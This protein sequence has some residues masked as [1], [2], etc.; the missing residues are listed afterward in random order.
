MELGSNV[1]MFDDKY[2]EL[3]KILN[4]F[5]NNKQYVQKI[6]HTYLKF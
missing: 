2:T 6:G 5:M 4:D 1:G 3:Y